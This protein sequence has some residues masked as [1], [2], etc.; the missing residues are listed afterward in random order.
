MIRAYAVAGVLAALLA[1]GG[2][3]WWQSATIKSLRAENARLVAN[4]ETL[5]RVSAK[6]ARARAVE[7][8]RIE[9]LQQQVMRFDELRDDIEGGSDAHHQ[10][11][12]TVLRAFR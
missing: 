2:L 12:D 3:F 11:S 9:Q 4:V 5:E 7:Q 8:R 6:E 10:A 1:A